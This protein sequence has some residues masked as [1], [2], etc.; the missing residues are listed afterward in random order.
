MLRARREPPPVGEGTEAEGA[1]RR[2]LTVGDAEDHEPVPRGIRTDDDDAGHRS[3]ALRFFDRLRGDVGR[4]EGAL[5]REE[6]RSLQATLFELLECKR[7][8]DQA[9]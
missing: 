1:G 3:S 5:T 9:R 7:L 4:G 2:N 6:I 8:L